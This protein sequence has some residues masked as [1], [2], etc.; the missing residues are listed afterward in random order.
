MV[1][2]LETTLAADKNWPTVQLKY[3]INLFVMTFRPIIYKA[4]DNVCELI[5]LWKI[6]VISR[7][8]NYGVNIK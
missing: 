5:S 7:W 3:Y 8:V 6:T 1:N 2:A 4:D